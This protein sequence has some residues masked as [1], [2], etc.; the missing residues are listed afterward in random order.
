MDI[1]WLWLALLRI[2]YHLERLSPYLFWKLFVCSLEYQLNYLKVASLESI[3][4]NNRHDPRLKLRCMQQ[5]LDNLKALRG[6]AHLHKGRLD[7]LGIE[8]LTHLAV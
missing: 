7:H 8:T 2:F 6:C 1:K 5:D 4:Q 3:R